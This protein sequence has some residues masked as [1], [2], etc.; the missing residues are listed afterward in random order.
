V[1]ASARFNADI[2][3]WLVFA[4]EKAPILVAYRGE[5]VRRPKT[6]EWDL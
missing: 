3:A 4:H 6:P 2:E 1:S 5:A